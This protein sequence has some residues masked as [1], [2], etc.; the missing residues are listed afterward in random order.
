LLFFFFF[1]F[2]ESES[3]DRV[4]IEEQNQRQCHRSQQNS[5]S[6]F[7]R[8]EAKTRWFSKQQSQSQNVERQSGFFW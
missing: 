5:F 3:I 4:G 1:F 6:S 2:R 8:R 7:E